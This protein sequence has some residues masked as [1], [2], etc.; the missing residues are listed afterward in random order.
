M[1][2]SHRIIGIDVSTTKLALVT[3]YNSRFNVVEL[4]SSTSHSWEER[5]D[6]LH[7]Q[8]ED[9][10][11]SCLKP[12]D[13]VFIEEIPYVQNQQVFAKLV[14]FMALCRFVL[15]S[16]G[17]SCTYVNNS[18]WKRSVGLRGKTT[19]DDIRKKAVELFGEGKLKSLS[20]DAVDAL[21]VSVYGAIIS[22]GD[23]GVQVDRLRG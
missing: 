5:L 16:H 7:A 2:I 20:Q 17:Y 10:V 21:L 1:G 22:E 12:G 4:V 13:R 18:T 14:H 19:K 11:G 23:Y 3:L 9:F 6:D 15:R 8:F